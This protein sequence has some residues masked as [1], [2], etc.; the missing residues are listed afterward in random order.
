MK[1]PSLQF[2]S[3]TPALTQCHSHGGGHR[4]TPTCLVA[5]SHL[6][7]ALHHHL[8]W[9]EA[10]EQEEEEEFLRKRK[11]PRTEWAT[12]VKRGRTTSSARLKSQVSTFLA[13]VA[14]TRNEHEQETDLMLI[15]LVCHTCCLAETINTS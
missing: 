2:L 15:S 7:A 5:Q 13:A 3:P 1:L 12:R 8:S 11:T 10:Q 6:D 14:L 4:A 9:Q